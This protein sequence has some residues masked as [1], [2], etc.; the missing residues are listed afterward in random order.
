MSKISLGQLDLLALQ[1]Y[2]EIVAGFRKKD[3]K[4]IDVQYVGEY[5]HATVNDLDSPT[6]TEKSPVEAYQVAM[7]ALDDLGFPISYKDENDIITIPERQTVLNSLM[8][9]GIPAAEF[10]RRVESDTIL[11]DVNQATYNMSDDIRNLKDE[12]YQLK[13]QLIKAGTIKDSNVYNG[14]I[15]AF[16]E[17]SPKHMVDTG[18]IVTSVSGYSVYVESLGDLITGEI[19]VLQ[20]GEYYNIQKISY[21][22]GPN[23]IVLCKP[24]TKQQEEEEPEIYFSGSIMQPEAQQGTTIKRSLGKSSN[25]KFMFGCEPKDGRVVTEQSKYIVK[26]GVERVKVFELDHSGSGFGTE[27]KIPSS[28][29]NNII[30]KVHVSLAVKGDPGDIKGEFYKIDPVTNLPK[31]TN[32]GQ[33]LALPDFVTKSVS[34]M[35][36]SGWFNDF[37]LELTNEMIVQPGEKYIFVLTRA[38][39]SNEN[40]VIDENNK[41]YIGGFNDDECLDDVHNDCYIKSLGRLYVSPEDT[42][43]FLLLTTKKVE[44]SEF[45]KL[46]YGLYTCN[47]DVYQSLANRIRVELCINQEGLFKVKDNNTVSLAKAKTNEIDIESR[48]PK[49]FKDKVFDGGDQVV[50][51]KQIGTVS[52][53]GNN[54][55]NIIPSSDIYVQNNAEVYRVGYE[56]QVIASNKVLEPT[57]YGAMERYED[58]E[59]Y[60]LK[61]VGVVPGRDMMRP[62]KSSDRL[63]FEAEFYNQNDLDDIKL[64]SF[65]HIEVQIR[66]FGHVDNNVIQANEELEGAIFD[67]AVSVDRAYTKSEDEVE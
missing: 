33:Q 19:I 5:E 38:G 51:G 50:I 7:A 43:M 6:E 16:I 55:S 25:G 32:N 29:Q 4:A 41:W 20:N 42:D 54:N 18:V 52:S 48:S 47:F 3:D 61:L 27:I 12:L 8:L 60:P 62:D 59:V 17:T 14:F 58:A 37:E 56:V 40:V 9:D 39:Q 57:M 28:L 65:N 15:D 46:N 13:N 23:E 35:A 45:K 34:P 10:L 66:W 36:A 11:T 21:F 53:V 26:D 64:K 2:F 31:Y 67:I 1:Q 44:A 30:S 63:I 24:G 49:S 22:N